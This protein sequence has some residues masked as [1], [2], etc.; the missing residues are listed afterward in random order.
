[1]TDCIPLWGTSRPTL[2][3]RGVLDRPRI[4]GSEETA[5]SDPGGMTTMSPF[6]PSRRRTPFRVEGETATIV[7]S[8]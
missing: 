7:R 8:R 4:P 5:E 6:R 2:T 3:M 1:M